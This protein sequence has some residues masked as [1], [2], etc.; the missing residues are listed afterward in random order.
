MTTIV[1]RVE[2]DANIKS[3]IVAMRLLKG[4]R[5][6]VSSIWDCRRNPKALKTKIAE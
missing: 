6:H 2:S 3:I 4:I 5:G 1:V